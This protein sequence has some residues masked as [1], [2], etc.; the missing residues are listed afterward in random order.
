MES[1][2]VENAVKINILSEI[3]AGHCEVRHLSSSTFRPLCV[4]QFENISII[5]TTNGGKEFRI[6]RFNGCQLSDDHPD[7]KQATNKIGLPDKKLRTPCH[8]RPIATE[9]QAEKYRRGF[10]PK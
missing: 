1:R 4:N 8:I 2:C 3:Y 10:T 9:V 5:A 7:I 6:F